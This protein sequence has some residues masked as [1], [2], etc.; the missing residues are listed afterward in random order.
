[1]IERFH[2][3]ARFRSRQTHLD[4]SEA[5]PGFRFRSRCSRRSRKI[6]RESTL[7]DEQ[8]KIDHLKR[9][10]LHVKTR[11]NSPEERPFVDCFPRK[12]LI[13]VEGKAR[14]TKKAWTDEAGEAMSVAL[15]SVRHCHK[16]LWW[17]NGGT[18]TC[19]TYQKHFQ[20]TQD[21]ER[22][23]RKQNF[24]QGFSKSQVAKWVQSDRGRAPAVARSQLCF[25]LQSNHFPEMLVLLVKSLSGKVSPAK[26]PFSWKGFPARRV[27]IRACVWL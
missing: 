8:S 19:S 13:K 24:G 20:P 14:R 10:G 23:R 27:F 17:T 6:G 26:L 4:D 2:W 1:M 16:V 5:S 12:G 18:A 22:S 7:E 25:H 3:R 15:K 21:V 11:C 9:K